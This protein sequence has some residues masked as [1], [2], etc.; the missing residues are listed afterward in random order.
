MSQKVKNRL[1]EIL[2]RA[3]AGGLPSR[4]FDIFIMTL[5]SLNVIAVI[6]ETVESLSSRYMLFFWIFEIFLVSVFTIEY[7]LRLWT[8]TTDNRFKSSIKGRIQFALTPLA[9]VD[10]MAILPFYLPMIIPFDLR[11]IRAL[12]LFRLFRLFKMGRYSE[13]LITFGNVLKE[14]K[15]E[16]LMAV[17]SVLILL[18]IASSFNVLC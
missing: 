11:F 2:E 12:R 15:E 8:C 10:L 5:I 7:L 16:L 17:F 4:L 1:F 18:V 3:S 9:L 6:L 14:K 13:A